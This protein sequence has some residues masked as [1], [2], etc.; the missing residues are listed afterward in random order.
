MLNFLD[1]LKPIYESLKK[2]SKNKLIKEKDLI[3]FVGAPWTIT[4]LYDEQTIT[5]KKFI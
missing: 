1:K 2:T 5:K 3:G 4:C